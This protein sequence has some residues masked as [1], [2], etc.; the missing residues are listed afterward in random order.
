MNN[1]N[2]LY[3]LEESYSQRIIDMQRDPRIK[4]ALTSLLQ[5][6]NPFRQKLADAIRATH[7]SDW[8]PSIHIRNLRSKIIDL[9]KQLETV[10]DPIKRKDILKDLRN[11]RKE[12][13]HIRKYGLLDSSGRNTNMDSVGRI[14]E[15]MERLLDPMGLGAKYDLQYTTI[16]PDTFGNKVR[17]FFRMKPETWREPKPVYKGGFLNPTIYDDVRKLELDK[18]GNRLLTSEPFR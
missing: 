17:K 13:S 14:G 4:D 8:I 1:L 15:D 9:Q 6:G 2:P 16:V 12:L 11:S 7:K 5:K 10:T 18:H 3:Y